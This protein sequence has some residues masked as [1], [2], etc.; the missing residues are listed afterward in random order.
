MNIFFLDID[1]KQNAKYYF[2]KHCIKIILEII[3]MLYTSHWIS[4]NDDKWYENHVKILNLQPYKKS[5]YNHPMSIWIR[6]SKNNY[7]YACNLAA[8]LCQE[9]TRRYN[10]IAARIVLLGF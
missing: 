3:Q 1:I 10:K 8:E 2:N 5:H 7:M 6:S 9:Y 4:N